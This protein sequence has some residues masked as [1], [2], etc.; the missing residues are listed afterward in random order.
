[1][2]TIG[3][4]V[5][6]GTVRVADALHLRWALR[7]VVRRLPPALRV[8]LSKAQVRMGYLEG[9]TLVPEDA[10]VTSYRTALE[11][12]RPE[13]DQPGAAYLEFGVYIGTSMTC[14]HRA[15]AAD[16]APG[17]R[18]IGFDS[19]QGMPRGVEEEDD[20][21]WKEGDLFAD[22]KLTRSNLAKQGV[23]AA[24]VELVPGWFQDTLTDATRTRLGIERA[25]IVMVDCVLAS[26]TTTALAF[27]APLIRDRSVIYFDDWA[28]V[29]LDDRGLGERVAFEAWLA[30]H[31]EFTAEEQPAL[32]YS[33]DAKAF[34]VSRI[35]S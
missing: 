13:L 27:L 17:P 7:W 22:M 20:R 8:R 18:L 9:L 33:N 30:E 6:A 5:L 32:H 2:P 35:A 11:L 31:P 25:P 10:L 1:M 12:V 19:F 23:P 29:D 21:R 3:G 26:A 28:V 34:L 15:V 24:D 4:R 16:G 14:M